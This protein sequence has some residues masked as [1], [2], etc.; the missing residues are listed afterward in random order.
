LCFKT[1]CREKACVVEIN[2]LIFENLTMELL[3]T[4]RQLMKH[5]RMDTFKDVVAQLLEKTW[6]LLIEYTH[7]HLPTSMG[8]WMNFAFSKCQIMNVLM[9]LIMKQITNKTTKFNLHLS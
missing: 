7:L 6:K 8:K 2:V 1:Q 9:E 4:L 5:K 3:T